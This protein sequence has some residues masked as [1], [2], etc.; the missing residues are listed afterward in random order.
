MQNATD[1]VEALFFDVFGTVVDWRTS[2]IWE[3]EEF[4]RKKG[5]MADWGAFAD[6]WRRKY[7]PSMEEVRS[8]RRPFVTLDVLHRESL[9]EALREFS[10]PGLNNDEVQHLTMAWHRLEPWPDAVSGL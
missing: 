1:Q 8:G 2:I 6:S 3:L 10:I 5:L 7:Q 9:I 4:G